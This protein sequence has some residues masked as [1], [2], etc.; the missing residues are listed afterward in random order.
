M[1]LSAADVCEGIRHVQ[2]SDD[3]VES[4]F[5]NPA[6]LEDIRTDSNFMQEQDLLLADNEI[7]VIAKLWW[8]RR[9]KGNPEGIM[10]DIPVFLKDIDSKYPAAK[11]IGS[12]VIV[13]V[14]G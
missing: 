2:E 1:V 3:T 6:G 5:V 7:N 10:F 11:I 9:D 12:R 8:F 14:E 4:I 13:L